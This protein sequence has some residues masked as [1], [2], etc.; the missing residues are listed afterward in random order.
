[1]RLLAVHGLESAG[2]KT[3]TWCYRVD[4]ALLAELPHYAAGGRETGRLRK[5]VRYIA[6]P[7]LRR[8]A[9]SELIRYP[10]YST[11]PVASAYP[12]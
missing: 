10:L 9:G 4:T 8:T 6:Q 1:M 5:I 2:K 3:R 12:V 7:S 11:I